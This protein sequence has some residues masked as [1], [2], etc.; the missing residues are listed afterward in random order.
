VS[1]NPKLN[2]SSYRDT[3]DCNYEAHEDIIIDSL[4]RNFSVDEICKTISVMSR[5]K[6]CDLSGNVADFFIDAKDFIAPYLMCIF[7]H[8]FDT[9]IYPEEWSKGVIVPIHKKGCKSDPSN[10]RGITLI[11]TMSKV[12]S[13]LLRNRLNA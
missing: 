11:N 6:S 10:Y 3:N 1:N 13:L 2:D 7:N 8:I 5:Y 12:F 9:G 4:D